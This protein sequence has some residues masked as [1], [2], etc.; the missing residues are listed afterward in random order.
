MKMQSL[1][2]KRNHV[3]FGHRP[4]HL[5]DDD[6][7]A[8]WSVQCWDSLDQ[9]DHLILL[10]EQALMMDSGWL[11]ADLA[12]ILAQS[13]VGVAPAAVPA[14]HRESA[15]N[16]YNRRRSFDS[17]LLTHSSSSSSYCSSTSPPAT[18]SSMSSTTMSPTRSNRSSACKFV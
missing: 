4:E 14:V 8:A 15:P 1:E 18:M 16:S 10:P 9:V 17:G 12:E 5:L 13:V 2:E 3:T 11:Q 6:G 7:S